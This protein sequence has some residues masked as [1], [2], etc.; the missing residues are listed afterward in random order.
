[1]EGPVSCDDSCEEIAIFDHSMSPEEY[2]QNRERAEFVA[3]AI[4][5]MGPANREVL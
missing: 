5:G 4:G 2:C 1:L 3:A